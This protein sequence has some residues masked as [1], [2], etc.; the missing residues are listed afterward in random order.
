MQKKRTLKGRMLR[1]ILMIW[2]V[3]M[4]IAAVGGFLLFESTVRKQKISD[5]RAELYQLTSQLEYALKDVQKF[6]ETILIDS[7]LQ[8]TL[9]QE[10]F[11]D[12][13]Q[14][15]SAYDCIA[16]RLL[17]YNNLRSYI[18]DSMLKM[19][20]GL[21][22]GT[23]F[24]RYSEE[25][26]REE[27]IQRH[28][29]E[30]QSYSEVYDRGDQKPILC[31]QVKMMDKYQFG[32][33]KGTLYLEI[34]LE[35]FLEQIKH[36]AQT[37]PYV[38]LVNE[39]GAAL[40]ENPADGFPQIAAEYKEKL[41]EDRVAKVSGGYLLCQPVESTGWQLYALITNQY[42]W[43]RSRFVLGF[44]LLSLLAFLGLTVAIISQAMDNII[45]PI[46]KLSEWMQAFE[47]GDADMPE[48]IQT[49][50]EIETLYTCCGHM[51]QKIRRGEEEAVRHA[52][53]EREMQF[54]IMLSQINPHYLYNVLHTVVY[55]ASAKGENDV[56]EIVH[57]LLYS[58]QE[59]LNIGENS[60][61]ST[62]RQELELLAC[63]LKIQSYR[64]PGAYAVDVQCD[65]ALK[66][67]VVP[68]TI[69]QP[70]VENAIFHG[71]LAEERFGHISVAVYAEGDQLRIL[72]KDDG[73]GISELS[74]AQFR[75]DCAVPVEEG[76][77]KHIGISHIRDRILF[78]YGGDYGM[79]I[80]RRPEG[81]TQVLL[82]LPLL[83]RKRQTEEGGQL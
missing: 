77:R 76:N 46:T 71:I 44:F 36:Y 21:W 45:C 28:T 11:S 80:E 33:Q 30:G 20:S 40:Y 60:I 83:K 68:K 51:V 7:E 54:D 37:N 66:D 6:A 2:V 14:R 61:E 48:Q 39:N 38:Y 62:I 43:E 24:V 64:Y 49:G 15:Q 18:S 56:V 57:A 4:V 12:E 78:L 74:L 34:Y 82:R 50:D 25:M 22:Y 70:L 27:L 75:Q 26:P 73:V 41:A 81:G 47:N 23:S 32:Q 10:P 65:E 16:N 3:S 29:I 67:C 5:Q 63:Y 9:A 72:V 59:T 42:L 13:Y 35:Y 31:Y 19:E 79:E 17:F 1:R 69:V 8:N 52:R 55:L 58:L 53:Q